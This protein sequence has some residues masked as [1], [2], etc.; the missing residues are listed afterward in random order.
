M[1]E[2]NPVTKQKRQINLLKFLTLRQ[3]SRMATRPDM[4]IQFAKDYANA[5]KNATGTKPVIKVE[6]LVSLNNRPYQYLIDPNVDL[7][8]Q[9][10][11][12]FPVPWIL[13]LK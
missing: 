7:T 13:Q 6:D 11:P 3:L 4:I 10:D 12:I 5:Q 9:E 2:I 1:Y 8:T